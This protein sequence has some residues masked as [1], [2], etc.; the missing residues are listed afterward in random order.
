MIRSSAE[1]YF[2]VRLKP[3]GAYSLSG[4]KEKGVSHIELRMIDLNPLSEAG[5]DERDAIFLQL[6]I[7]YLACV[8]KIGFDADSQM[9]SVA[10][11]K[12]A[13][14]FDL[15]TVHLT[16]RRGRTQSIADA[17]A[18]LLERMRMFFSFIDSSM[19]YVIDY[20]MEKFLDIQNRYTWQIRELFSDG[21][22]E[23]GAFLFAG[24][25][26]KL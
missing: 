4:L 11:T 15:K 5:I 13:A 2:P 20:Q 12:N 26:I 8:D 25:T 6:L 7:I 17:A 23:G 19:L 21:F 14:R 1:L 18:G 3:P 9:M 16:D 24:F 10:N 22:V